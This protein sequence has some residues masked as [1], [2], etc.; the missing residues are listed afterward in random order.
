M[1]HANLGTNG[2]KVAVLQDDFAYYKFF[3]Q[4]IFVNIDK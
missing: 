2:S 4:K 3:V 1:F